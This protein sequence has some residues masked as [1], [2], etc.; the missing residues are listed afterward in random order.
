MARI[1]PKM[2]NNLRY[3]PTR[4]QDRIYKNEG[5][6]TI[7]YI[8]IIIKILVI[9]IYEVVISSCIYHFPLSC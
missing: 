2:P 1:A 4:T 3:F 7:S 8:I 5:R 9:L 6:G